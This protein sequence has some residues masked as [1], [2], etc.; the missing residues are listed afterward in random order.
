MAPSSFARNASTRCIAILS[1]V[2]V[3]TVAALG[4]IGFAYNAPTWTFV[5]GMVVVATGVGSA[6][7]VVFGIR[8]GTAMRAN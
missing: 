6:T 4:I 7:A 2:A 3:I 5:V 1:L 8:Q